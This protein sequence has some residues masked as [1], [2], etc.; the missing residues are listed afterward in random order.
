MRFKRPK[1]TT[2][3]IVFALIIYGVVLLITIQTAT[4]EREIENNRLA[5][6]A[7][8]L[9]IEVA[10]LEYAIG[11]YLAYE[12]A[13]A[14]LE[15]LMEE[16]AVLDLRIIELED[17]YSNPSAPYTD[18]EELN[19]LRADRALLETEII[20]A[21]TERDLL[22]TEL[23]IATANFNAADA[24]DVIAEIARIHLGLVLPGEIVLHKNTD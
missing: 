11:R 4:N 23:D 2:M 5:L 13:R 12:N 1:L 22:Q 3:F 16:A 17:I 19:V 14:N 21:Q 10:E 24:S 8:R 9:E 20:R 7:S 6:E 15:S 18:N